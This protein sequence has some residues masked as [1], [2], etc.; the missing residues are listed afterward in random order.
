MISVLQ[1][2]PTLQI[3]NFLALYATFFN[4]STSCTSLHHHHVS[5]SLPTC[6]ST[7]D[8]TG[9]QNG[10]PSFLPAISNFLE[11]FFQLRSKLLSY[12]FLLQLPIFQH[13]SFSDSPPLHMA[14]SKVCSNRSMLCYTALS[15]IALQSTGAMSLLGLVKIRSSWVSAS[16]LT[17][18]TVLF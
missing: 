2:P 1:L 10:C 14:H 9:I 18:V 6:F 8:L 13:S 7:S 5:L 17:Y 3:S 11:I 4:L 12:F 16:P 15:G